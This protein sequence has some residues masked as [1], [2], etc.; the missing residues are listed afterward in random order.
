MR[1]FKINIT[2]DKLLILQK[3]LFFL[4]YFIV[5]GSEDSLESSYNFSTNSLPE[6]L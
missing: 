1:L 4:H 5:M 3:I 6:L 2:K